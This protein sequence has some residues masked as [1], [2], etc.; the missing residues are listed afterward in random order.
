MASN[1]NRVKPLL[2]DRSDVESKA[3]FM[4]EQKTVIISKFNGKSVEGYVRSET[5]TKK[6]HHVTINLDGT[7]IYDGTCT[8]E[9]VSFYGIPCKHML[10]LRNNA[11]RIGIIS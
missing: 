10:R 3:T 1:R 6:Y 11:V 2:Y 9:S 5:R 8:C 4:N 7:R